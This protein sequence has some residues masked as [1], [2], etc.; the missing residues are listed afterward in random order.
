M[1]YKESA[2]KLNE[3]SDWVKS[4]E[5]KYKIK[6]I[7]KGI[8]QINYAI[9]LIQAMKEPYEFYFNQLNLTK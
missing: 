4:E 5:E 3:F 8:L 9:I 2:A 6:L 1:N 7:V